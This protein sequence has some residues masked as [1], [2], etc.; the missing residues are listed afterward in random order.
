MKQNKPQKKR[1]E[2]SCVICREKSDKKQLLRIVKDKEGHIAYD[3][4]G[5]APGRGAYICT[6]EEC[7][8][9]FFT[10]NVLARAFRQQ[11]DQETIQQIRKDITDKAGLPPETKKIADI[12]EER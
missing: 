10:K 3:P 4:T 7:L 11:V 1:P 5:K 9:A 8:N 2:R 12:G 6:N